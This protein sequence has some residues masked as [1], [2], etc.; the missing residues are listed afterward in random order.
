MM[1]WDI[2]VQ[3]DEFEGLLSTSGQDYRLA[4]APRCSCESVYLE[5]ILIEKV[6]AI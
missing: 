5:L 2:L 6:Q 4:A 3:A 1:A